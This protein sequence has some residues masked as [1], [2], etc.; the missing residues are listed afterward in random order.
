MRAREWLLVELQK[1]PACEYLAAFGE[2]SVVK[3][4]ANSQWIPDLPVTRVTPQDVVAAL[5]SSE[6][7]LV[8][9]QIAIVAPEGSRAL[10]LDSHSGFLPEEPSA[11]EIVYELTYIDDA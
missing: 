7:Q 11:Q 3:F 2:A 6:E 4:G 8:F 9:D 10:V 1:L 5:R